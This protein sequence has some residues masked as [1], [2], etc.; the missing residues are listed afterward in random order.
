MVAIKLSAVLLS[1]LITDESQMMSILVASHT[2]PF[3]FCIYTVEVGE[4]NHIV[5]FR[6][7]NTNSVIGLA[8]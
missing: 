4:P 6:P 8:D 1:S 2:P 5:T 3:Q 7:P